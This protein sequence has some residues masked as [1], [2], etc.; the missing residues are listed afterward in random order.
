M[1]NLGTWTYEKHP[2]TGR[3]IRVYK[4]RVHYS[5]KPE[6]AKPSPVND[7]AGREA[8]LNIPAGDRVADRA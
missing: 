1:T 5:A 8:G 2:K 6:S 3:L 4:T 7:V